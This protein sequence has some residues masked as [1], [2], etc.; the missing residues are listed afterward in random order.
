[1]TAS[2]GMTGTRQ[3]PNVL[4]AHASPSRLPD[5]QATGRAAQTGASTV[6]VRGAALL[7]GRVVHVPTAPR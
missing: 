3:W 2:V 6:C 4:A 5:P 1:M 7:G